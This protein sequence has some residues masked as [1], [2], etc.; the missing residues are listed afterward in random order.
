[1]TE[2]G[3]AVALDVVIEPN[4]VADPSQD[5]GQRRLAHLDATTAEGPY[6][7][8]VVNGTIEANLQAISPGGAGATERASFKALLDPALTPGQS[9]VL[10]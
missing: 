2:K 6:R 10:R 4:A 7:V 9:S 1:M 5:T 8:T 3:Q